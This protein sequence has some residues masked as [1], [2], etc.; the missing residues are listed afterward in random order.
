M[1]V[2]VVIP[3]SGEW[4]LPRLRNCLN[5]IESQTLPP[6]EVIIPYLYRDDEEVPDLTEFRKGGYQVIEREYSAPGFPT[7]LS[8]NVG[9]RQ[10]AGGLAV[11]V[12]ADAVVHPH[13][14]E[15]CHELLADKQAF[16]R[17]RTRMMP[18]LP[19]HEIYRQ[20]D[21]PKRFVQASRKVEWAFGP[22][23]VIAAPMNVV[24]RIRGWDEEFVGYGPV[25]LDFVHR[26]KVAGLKELVLPRD[27]PAR[28]IV[29]MHQHHKRLRD[30]QSLLREKN[31]ARY[32]K[33]LK[34][35]KAVRNTEFWGV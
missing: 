18:Q 30:K 7:A 25:V 12:D 28:H 31:I 21:P 22:G 1:K 11:T 2:S 20:L 23:C 14:L 33:T 16:I 27:Y 32:E 4:Y 5:A 17:I 29:N 34:S 10:V 13:T 15:V 35:N 6:D 19:E 3:V 9:L 24:S 8:R 26:L